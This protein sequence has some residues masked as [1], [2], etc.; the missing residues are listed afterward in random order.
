MRPTA[1]HRNAQ[2]SPAHPGL[3]HPGLAH[4][5]L[6]HS[7]MVNQ[8][9]ILVPRNRARRIAPAD[10][11]ALEKLAHAIEYLT[12]ELTLECMTAQS[13]AFQ[14][15]GAIAAIELLKKCNRE[16]YLACPLVPTFG[17]RLRSW[18]GRAS[19]PVHIQASR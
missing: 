8:G 15:H 1:H 2:S 16:I 10:G 7:G 13:N 14:P 3:A 19:E 11:K 12:D 17:E 9:M 18:F 4:S 6:A 5:G